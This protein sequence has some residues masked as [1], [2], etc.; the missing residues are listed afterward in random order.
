MCVLKMDTAIKIHCPPLAAD[1]DRESSLFWQRPTACLG[2]REAHN[3]HRIIRSFT[4]RAFWIRIE[5]YH[6]RW[7]ASADMLRCLKMQQFLALA[8]F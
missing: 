8:E 1:T 6:N 4:T 3:A 5:Q 2:E 7:R